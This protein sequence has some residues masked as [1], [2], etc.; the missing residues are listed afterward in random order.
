LLGQ[1]DDFFIG[2]KIDCILKIDTYVFF[3]LF[4]DL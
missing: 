2:N 4:N 1:S 3:H